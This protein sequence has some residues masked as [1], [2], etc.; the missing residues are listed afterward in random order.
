MYAIDAKTGTE[1]WSY[2]FTG[3]YNQVYGSPAVVNGVVYVGAD[4]TVVALDANTGAVLWSFPTAEGTLVVASP[5]VADGVVYIYAEG[6]PSYLYAIDAATGTLLWSRS[7][8]A[9]GYTSPA[10]AYGMVFIGV[11][12]NNNKLLGFLYALNARTGAVLWGYNTGFGG[13]VSSPAVANGVVYVVGEK[14]Y[15][16]NARN[17]AELWSYQKPNNNINSSPVVSNGVLY[18]DSVGGYLYAFGLP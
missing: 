18:V 7:I 17:G 9:L 5:A 6:L 12:Y 11:N 16:L 4:T 10:V 14:L 1:L 3:T 15:A 13:V 2:H 8:Q